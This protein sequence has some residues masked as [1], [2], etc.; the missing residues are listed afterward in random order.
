[1]SIEYITR[2]IVRNLHAYSLADVSICR[3]RR[4]ERITSKYTARRMQF[5]G[6]AVRVSLA[7]PRLHRAHEE[8]QAQLGMLARLAVE[9]GFNYVNFKRRNYLYLSVRDGASTSALLRLAR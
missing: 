4:T 6:R 3:T 2:V 7:L 1:M 8:L 5:E 9:S